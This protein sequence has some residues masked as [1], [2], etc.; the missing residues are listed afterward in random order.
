MLSILVTLYYLV[1]FGTIVLLYFNVEVL[2]LK[3]R[4]RKLKNYPGKDDDEVLCEL[5]DD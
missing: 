3:E 5:L 1:Y 4:K 2:S